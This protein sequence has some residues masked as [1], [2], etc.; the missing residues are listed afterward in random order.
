MTNNQENQTTG[1]T[2]AQGKAT[3]F[4]ATRRCVKHLRRKARKEARRLERAAKAQ[5]DKEAAAAV[6]IQCCA[7]KY[8]CYQICLDLVLDHMF[9][10]DV[11]LIQRFVRGAIARRN[12]A[13]TAA[14]AA[15]AAAAATVIQRVVR[16]VV[17]RALFVTTAAT[18]V[19]VRRCAAT[20][21]QRF[22]IRGVATARAANARAANARAANATVMDGGNNE[23]IENIETIETIENIEN[24]GNNH[25]INVKSKKIVR[26][27]RSTTN[28]SPHIKIPITSR[29]LKKRRAAAAAAAAATA[30]TAALVGTV[31]PSTLPPRRGTP[32]SRVSRLQAMLA[33]MM[34]EE[35][36]QHH[37]P[38]TVS[39]SPRQA[40]ASIASPPTV[41]K[42]PKHLKHVKCS[43]KQRRTNNKMNS[44]QKLD[45]YVST[46]RM[47]KE[48]R[49]QR[50]LT[51]PQWLGSRNTRFS[52]G[53]VFINW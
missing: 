44:Q 27:F 29:L 36:E 52:T 45:R 7:R 24:I 9:M 1:Q 32:A 43:M 13:A 14:A 20:T 33:R 46:Q 3:I 4:R 51:N 21:I 16:G 18:A 49:Q 37:S 39:S 31:S 48:A 26:D 35:K 47:K 50:A 40:T 42:T 11:L 15:A 2:A 22:F 6:I 34:K 28:G 23:N 12:L 5:F 41:R 30:A 19:A 10:C 17:G 53:N 8:F 25:E 38:T